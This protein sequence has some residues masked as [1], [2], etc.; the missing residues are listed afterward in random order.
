MATIKCLNKS[1]DEFVQYVL[2][3]TRRRNVI[4]QSIGIPSMWKV[5]QC[6]PVNEQ[7][8]RNPINLPEFISSVSDVGNFS[9]QPAAFFF[10]QLPPSPDIKS[11]LINVQGGCGFPSPLHQILTNAKSWPISSQSTS[12][13]PIIQIFLKINQKLFPKIRCRSRVPLDRTEKGL[14]WQRE[15]SL[16]L[17][18][19]M[20]SM[21]DV[22]EQSRSENVMESGQKGSRLVSSYWHLLGGFMFVYSFI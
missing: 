12:K 8:W 19:K 18:P 1:S 9:L 13:A 22:T 4:S 5:N 11:S 14:A 15:R 20:T 7:I 3:Q 16:L 6:E 10:N 17:F 21:A 2:P